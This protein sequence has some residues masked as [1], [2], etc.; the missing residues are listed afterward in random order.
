MLE[1]SWEAHATTLANAET[2]DEFIEKLGA[3]CQ[4]YNVDFSRPSNVIYARDTRPSG[5]M[6][7]E[8]LEDGLKAIG[9]KGRNEGIQTTPILHYLVRCVN[10]KD[11]N[12]FYG[13]DT[14]QGYYTKISKAFKALM[15]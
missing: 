8:A 13:E 1:Q 15:V 5:N 3:L 9:A 7:M 10:T 6:L 12:E 14:V 2:T 11:T 4:K